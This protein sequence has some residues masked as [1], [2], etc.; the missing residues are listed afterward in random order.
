MQEKQ[1]VQIGSGVPRRL[2]LTA[3]EVSHLLGRAE[4]SLA[5]DRCNCRGLPYVKIGRSIRY[6]AS[7]VLAYAE[8]HRID[9]ESRREAP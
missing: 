5:N 1:E 3:K 7:D 8:A 2:L 9:P 4:Q 6:M